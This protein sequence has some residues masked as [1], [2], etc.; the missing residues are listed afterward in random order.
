MS[1]RTVKQEIIRGFLRSIQA[2]LGKQY[3]IQRILDS[4]PVMTEVVME[5]SAGNRMVCARLYH[6]APEHHDTVKQLWFEHAYMLDGLSHDCLQRPLGLKNLGQEI[7]FVSEFKNHPDC[8]H[9]L[10]QISHFP[11]DFAVR[12]AVEVLKAL[13]VVYAKGTGHFQLK[14]SDILL[15]GH[16]GILLKNFGLFDFEFEIA[17]ILG[18]KEL[19]DPRYVSPE[20]FGDQEL[21]VPADIYSLGTCLFE[22]VTGRVPYTGDFSAVQAGHLERQ[23]PNP[24]AMNPEISLGLSRVLMRALAKN[25]AQRFGHLSEF[26]TALAFLLPVAERAEITPKTGE[27]V[28]LEATDKAKIISDMSSAKKLLGDGDTQE[29]LRVMD[30]LL[31]MYGDHEEARRLWRDIYREHHG[32]E[33]AAKIAQARQK[34]EQNQLR[35]ALKDVAEVLALDPH[36]DE[37]LK[38]QAFVFENLTWDADVRTKIIDTEAFLTRADEAQKAGQ[39]VLA[40]RLFF[41]V[42]QADIENARALEAL[43]QVRVAGPAAVPAAPKKPVP[44]P[45]TPPQPPPP[46]TPPTKAEPQPVSESEHAFQQSL[47]K[48]V[49][50]VQM[51]LGKKAH[52]EALALGKRLLPKFKNDP[53]LSALVEQAAAAVR[54]QT[55]QRGLE[56]IG[57][58]EKLRDYSGAYQVAQ[59]ILKIKPDHDAAKQALARAENQIRAG[60]ELAKFIKGVE[61]KEQAGDFQTAMSMVEK[62]LQNNTGMPQLA[63]LKKRLQARLEQ[64]GEAQWR[65]AEAQRMADRGNI[66][67]AMEKLEAT[68]QAFPSH[69]QARTLLESLRS[70]GAPA[71]AEPEQETVRAPT[72]PHAPEKAAP[73]AKKKSNIVLFASLG[74]FAVVLV[75]AGVLWHLHRKKMNTYRGLY[76]QAANQEQLGHWEN[77]KKQFEELF[78]V[79]PKF[80]DV[81]DR[82]RGLEDKI[83]QRKLKIKNCF[84]IA[85][86]YLNDGNI[87]DS[88][89][90]NAVAYLRQILELD[91]DNERA[92]QMLAEAR[93]QQM[94]SARSMVAEERILEARDVYFDV[95]RIDP[96]FEDPEFEAQINEWIYTNR[97]EPELKKFDRAV[98]RKRWDEAF[99][100]SAELQEQ[101]P[102]VPQLQQRLDDL[103][104]EF[105]SNMIKAQD[106][107]K[108]EQ[109]L[110]W[111]QLMLRIQP[112]NQELMDRRNLLSREL[113]NSNISRLEGQIQSAMKNKDFYR[114]GLLANE[115]KQLDSENPLASEAYTE[116]L[117]Q[118]EQKIDR[119]KKGNPR[120]ALQTYDQLIKVNNWK[121]YRDERDRLKKTTQEFDAAV[122]RT[123]GNLNHLHENLI[124]KIDQ[125]LDKY[126]DFDQDPG[127][128][129]LV[130]LKEQANA[131]KEN[132]D[133]LLRWE[134][135][136]RD[137]ANIPYAEILERIKSANKFTFP[138]AKK[139]V[140]KLISDYQLKIN[141]YSGGVV[142]V[143]KQVIFELPP[144][145]AVKVFCQ[146]EA[147]PRKW[148]TETLKVQG[149]PVWNQSFSF[150]AVGGETLAFRLF[151]EKMFNK[152]QS[153][154]NLAIPGV[155]KTGKDLTF[156]SPDG[157]KIIIDVKRDR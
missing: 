44:P 92:R 155:P 52:A 108:Q 144:D 31:M 24:Q 6:V 84:M 148:R 94:E 55:I 126:P 62:A 61:A 9:Y 93:D 141:Q 104:A 99:S 87:I 154:G 36:Y 114:A 22:C 118:L 113:N 12:V 53:T 83:E 10:S 150:D 4:N 63:A 8:A 42:L 66:Q 128:Q 142:L 69:P 20:H 123:K 112:E 122:A 50:D 30:A 25:P 1:D 59:G 133:K 58:L 136:V 145:K 65:V 74:A 79:A 96:D 124:K 78:E 32:P 98:Q 43:S 86:E 28:A 21:M 13:E 103:Y 117:R 115:L 153:L 85:E 49:L 72:V 29:A 89:D 14:T 140:E 102:D 134:A 60:Q 119:Q 64:D 77:A 7:G 152:T 132:L 125:T 45:I 80:D 135:R 97:V 37:A 15:N 116:A 35:Q 111:L 95:K 130:R 100:I 57:Q 47:E 149:N 120:S 41:Q 90:E 19:L 18:T 3:R 46:P 33:M 131:E 2:N 5:E 51:L 129:E 54:E 127:F 82:I 73:P 147:G 38:L 26:K 40:E 68:L 110:S 106:A 48:A 17:K 88:T 137:D 70:G 91:A 81:R 56:K 11:P 146:I 23:V 76:D 101:L 16:G 157:W 156:T 107:N 109:V 34:I 121:R 71:E 39:S 139:P 143:V 27:E 151:A 105:E 75:V 138:F 67:G